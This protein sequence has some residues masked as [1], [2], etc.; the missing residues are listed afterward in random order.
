QVVCDPCVAPLEASQNASPYIHVIPAFMN[1]AVVVAPITVVAGTPQ[2]GE[3]A[4]AECGAVVVAP[5]TV[6]AGTP[7][8]GEPS[9]GFHVPD[10]WEWTIR[11]SVFDAGGEAVARPIT[12]ADAWEWAIRGS[13]FDAGGGAV[14]RL[15]TSA[16]AFAVRE[17]V[18]LK[19][20]HTADFEGIL[21]NP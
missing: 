19:P 6:V 11:G 2:A 14:A 1:Q 5:I 3:P 17:L 4:S 7:E 18:A 13:V 20:T 21:N 9:A 10:A 15:I 8:A 16:G 12:S